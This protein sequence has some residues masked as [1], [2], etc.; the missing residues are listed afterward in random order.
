MSEKTLGLYQSGDDEVAPRSGHLGRTGVS[1]AIDRTA[2]L[3]ED[4][5]PWPNTTPVAKH[6]THW[7]RIQ[8]SGR[9]GVCCLR[10]PSRPGEAL[11]AIAQN[12]NCIWVQRHEAGALDEDAVAADLIEQYEVRIAALER[13]RRQVGAGAGVCEGGSEKRTAA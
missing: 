8:A 5:R 7:S 10:D 1:S 13:P 2:G 6:R 11:R 4:E 9:T 12:L 3:S